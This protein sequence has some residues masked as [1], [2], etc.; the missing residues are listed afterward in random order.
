MHVYK[1]PDANMGADSLVLYAFFLCKI[2]N[3]N[4]IYY[5]EKGQQNCR[6]NVRDLTKAHEE[7]PF[8]TSI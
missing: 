3:C 8:L 4:S 6:G 1:E 7:I 5:W 2:A